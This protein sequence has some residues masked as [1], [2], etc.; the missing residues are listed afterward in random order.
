MAL[1]QSRLG[2]VAKKSR[3]CALSKSGLPIPSAVTGGGTP[4]ASAALAIRQC[5]LP[6][7]RRFT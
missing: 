4:A 2:K 7:D 1:G 6:R 3:T 5:W